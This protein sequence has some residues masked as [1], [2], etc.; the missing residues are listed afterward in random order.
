VNLPVHPMQMPQKAD[1][2]AKHRVG[3][4]LAKRIGRVPDGD[5]QPLGQL[6]DRHPS[7]CQLLTRS[8]AVS[9]LRAAC[10][11]AHLLSL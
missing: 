5:S 1:R 3:D 4:G 10:A 11:I 8:L 9:R 7:M 6:Q 2:I